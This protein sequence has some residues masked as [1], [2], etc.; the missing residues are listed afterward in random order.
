[1]KILICRRGWSPSGGAE[2]F[3]ARFAEGLNE[4]GI[5][6]VL[7]ADSRWPE[8]HWKFGKIE[9]VVSEGP[10]GFAHEVISVKK[11]HPG[12]VLF[13]MERV[14][15]AD[16]YR[17]GD[18]LH[19]SWL[20]RL[21]SEQGYV[22]G[23]LRRIKKNHREILSLEREM[24]KDSDLRIIC[25]SKM[26]ADELLHQYHFSNDRIAVIHNGYD[27]KPIDGAAI[28]LRRESLRKRLQIPETATVFLF[29]GTGWK[30]KGAQIL[31][32]AFHQ[33][34]N[35]N[36]W[37]LLVG[38]GSAMNMSH[39]RIRHVGVIK[40]PTDFYLASDIF[41][42]PTL[43]DPFSNACLEAAS[44][45]MPVITSDGNGFREVINVWPEAG[46]IVPLPRRSELW[47]DAM[48][49]WMEPEIRQK[50]GQSLACIPKQYTI[51]KNVQKTI[52][53]LNGKFHS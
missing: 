4:I 9:R 31:I 15:G 34:K 5:E 40:D 19:S 47:R 32:D 3:I 25:N 27:P 35:P 8:D 17:A 36:A 16:V 23:W 11:R 33:L 13:S 10:R 38:K 2:R 49:R 29:V 6:P 42:L 22:A 48:D 26:V 21:E 18:G 24:L 45:G 44:Y 43:Y 1:M 20:Q 28:R 7:I 39:P 30:R 37:L 52:D 46:Q 12:A 41:V 53:F 14:P 50:A 51:A